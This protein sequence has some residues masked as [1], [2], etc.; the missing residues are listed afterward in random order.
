MFVSRDLLLP[1]TEQV[2]ESH[3]DGG[4]NIGILCDWSKVARLA[5]LTRRWLDG[6]RLSF[7]LS[8]VVSSGRYGF[9]VI[10]NKIDLEQLGRFFKIHAVSIGKRVC[11]VLLKN[12]SAPFYL[13]IPKHA[14]DEKP[15][16]RVIHSNSLNAGD[17]LLFL[18][19]STQIHGKFTVTETEYGFYIN[20]KLNTSRSNPPSN[21]GRLI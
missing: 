7:K 2:R 3:Q 21:R 13:D 11:P 5:I 18:P 9:F 12:R 6:Q 1:A 15:L 16:G 20:Y 14:S 10:I 8:E 19:D 17:V 4:C